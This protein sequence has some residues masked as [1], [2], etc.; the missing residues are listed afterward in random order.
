MILVC[1]TIWQQSPT[2]MAA[3]LSAITQPTLRT[4]RLVNGMTTMTPQCHQFTPTTVKAAVLSPRM[5]MFST[6]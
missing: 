2:T 5:P 6:M 3:L 4:L 1:S